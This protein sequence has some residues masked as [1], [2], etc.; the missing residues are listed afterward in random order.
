MDG[1]SLGKAIAG[2]VI[3]MIVIAFIVG[4]VAAGVGGWLFS[5]GGTC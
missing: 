5:A 1:S 4:M 3:A 2:G